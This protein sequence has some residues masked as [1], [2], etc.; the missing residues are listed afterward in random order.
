MPTTDA[1]LQPGTHSI[2]LEAAK[3]RH[4]DPPWAERVVVTDQMQG[5]LICQAPGHPND[6]HY[7]HHDE[8]WLVME[9]EIHWE[10]EGQSGRTKAKAGDFVYVPKECFHHIH[11]VGEQPAIRLAISVAGERHLHDR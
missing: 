5:T 9:G 10:I 7:H 1:I 11:V 3:A 8:W 2:G 4:G 6:N